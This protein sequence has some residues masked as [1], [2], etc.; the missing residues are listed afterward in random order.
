MNLLGRGIIRL[1]EPLVRILV[2]FFPGFGPFHIIMTIWFGIVCWMI[3]FFFTV[4][5]PFIMSFQRAP[6][7]IEQ[8]SGELNITNSFNYDVERFDG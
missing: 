1:L 7:P 4:Y 2:F 3:K 6:L 5:I 8:S